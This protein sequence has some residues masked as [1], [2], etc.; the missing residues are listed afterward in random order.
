MNK[1]NAVTKKPIGGLVIMVLLNWFSKSH[2]NLKFKYDVIDTNWMDVDSIISI[3][4]MNYENEKNI[5]WLDYIDVTSLD[6][7]VINKIL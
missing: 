3:V 1:P 4:T 5:C 6:E 7:F 2:G